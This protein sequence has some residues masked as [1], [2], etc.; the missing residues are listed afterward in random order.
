MPRG[1]MD[2]LPPAIGSAYAHARRVCDAFDPGDRFKATMERFLTE[3]GAGLR[4]PAR[5]G[6]SLP[7]RRQ[8]R[9]HLGELQ[10]RVRVPGD[11]GIR[12][13]P[14]DIP[15]LRLAEKRVGMTF[16]YRTEVDVQLLLDLL[17]IRER[18]K[19]SWPRE[20]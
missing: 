17:V 12:V 2:A 8:W 4:S 20:P 9:G 7:E 10:V 11:A 6:Q 15:R 19:W 16:A 13:P 3:A 5:L 14:R 18:V 1:E